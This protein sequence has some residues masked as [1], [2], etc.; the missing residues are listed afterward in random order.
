MTR[1][2]SYSSMCSIDSC[3]A[4]YTKAMIA[5]NP[6]ADKIAMIDIMITTSV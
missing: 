6:I 5:I 4:R 1:G 2:S 3:L